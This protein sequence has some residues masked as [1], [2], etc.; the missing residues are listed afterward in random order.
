MQV[1]NVK[2]QDNL[3]GKVLEPQRADLWKLDFSSVLIGLKEQLAS[4]GIFEFPVH[5]YA[6][7]IT[8][9]RLGVKPEEF[10][11]GSCRFL[12]PG[13]DEALG[14]TKI[15]FVHDIGTSATNG[16]YQSK[17]VRVLEAWRSVVRSGRQPFSSEPLPKLN[18]NFKSISAFD[19]PV[20]LL[21]GGGRVQDD[22]DGAT[23]L[24]IA[25]LA[26]TDM[27][28]SAVYTLV[29]MWLANYQI[30]EV[31]NTTTGVLTVSATFCAADF[32]RES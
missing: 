8:L 6:T 32:R 10:Q 21:K 16:I 2:D 14:E 15:D 23:A 12:Y 29:K 28:V 17:V 30:N 11:E 31:G 3:W 9:P 7:K 1:F 25:K 5:Y 27:E 24:S 13:A 26:S 20:W 4:G 18:E 22:G 19:V